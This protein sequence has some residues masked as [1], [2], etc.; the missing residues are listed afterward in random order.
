MIRYR[1]KVRSVNLAVR[2]HLGFNPITGEQVFPVKIPDAP[3]P[4]GR[5]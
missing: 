2:N 5:A 1:G 4:P 3:R